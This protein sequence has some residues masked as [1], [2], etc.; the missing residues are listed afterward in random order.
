MSLHILLSGWSGVSLFAY[1]KSLGHPSKVYVGALWDLTKSFRHQNLIKTWRMRHLMG[2]ETFKISQSNYSIFEIL[3]FS[4][5]WNKDAGID[6]VTHSW[7]E[8]YS[9]G[10]R[11]SHWGKTLQLQCWMDDNSL[12]IPS[13]TL[14]KYSSAYSMLC[15]L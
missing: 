1:M 8:K 3:T 7:S 15:C 2:A 14:V 6:S 11:K 5:F 4:F 13:E 10:D 9:A 12:L